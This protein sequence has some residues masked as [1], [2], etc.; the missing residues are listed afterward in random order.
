MLPLLLFPAVLG[1]ACKKKQ[2]YL[3][4]YS[5]SFIGIALLGGAI[6]P[7]IYLPEQFL[8]VT[9]WLPNYRFVRLFAAETG[10]E[11]LFAAGIAAAETIALWCLLLFFMKRRGEEAVCEE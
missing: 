11:L 2:T 10:R 8:V 4:L 6:L 1:I 3:L 7:E 9:K 5:L